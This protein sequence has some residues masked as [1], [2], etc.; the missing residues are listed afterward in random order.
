MIEITVGQKREC[1]W[2]IVPRFLGGRLKAAGLLARKTNSEF[3]RGIDASLAEALRSLRV[4]LDAA[5]G[6]VRRGGA[7]TLFQRAEEFC[8]QSSDDDVLLEPSD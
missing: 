4:I 2:H 8:P 5:R 7:Q 3:G 6:S 1:D